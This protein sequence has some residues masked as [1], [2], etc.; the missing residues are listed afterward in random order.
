MP[1]ERISTSFK[2]I[3]L[4]FDMHPVQKDISVLLNET[5][6]KRSIKNIIQTTP[7]ERFFNLS[8]GSDVKP[9]LFEFIDFG[10]ASLLQDYIKV[11]IT[12]YEPR[13]EDTQVEVT[14]DSDNNAFEINIYFTIV[15]QTETQ[16]FS[17][18][19]EATR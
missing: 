2:D 1:T 8:F 16:Q 15:G 3:N 6:I 17:Y 12:N 18:L 4:S 14:P 9:T 19:L 13:V 10:T 5:A 11:A 7:N